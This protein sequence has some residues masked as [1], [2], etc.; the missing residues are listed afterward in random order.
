MTTFLLS[1]ADCRGRRAEIL[2]REQAAFPLAVALRDGRATLGEVFSFVSGLYFR[3]KLA[4]ARKYGGIVRVIVPGRGLLD[5]DLRVCVEHVHAFAQVPVDVRETAYVAPLTRDARALGT[6]GSVVLLGSIA[7]KKYVDPLAA[8]F[9]E[10]LLFPQA[11]VGR[12]DMS[13]G[14]MLLKAVESGVELVYTEVVGAVR[15]TREPGPKVA[16]S[17]TE[18]GGDNV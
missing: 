11:F 8:V 1:P 2:L 13:R 9:A 15:T 12:G 17:A 10:R 18:T 4:Y 6:E 5:P 14:S 7:T 3:G 16:P